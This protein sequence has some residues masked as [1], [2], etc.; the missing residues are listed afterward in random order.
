MRGRPPKPTNLK[1]LEG[2]P[3]KRRLNTNEPKP[4]SIAP[5]RPEWLAPE[6]KR[7][8]SYLAPKLTALGLLTEVDRLDF[9]ML[10]QHWADYV[11]AVKDLRENGWSF[12][13]DKG[14]EGP[15][16]SVGKMHKASEKIAMLGAKFG[17][18]PSDRARLSLPE[19]KAADPFEE[20]LKKNA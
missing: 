1:I 7:M 10:C 12:S 6:A 3:G 9:A 20:F 8:W 2:N 14:Y 19:Q 18:S 4:L 5:T 16:S 15:R 13:T 17:L 11:D